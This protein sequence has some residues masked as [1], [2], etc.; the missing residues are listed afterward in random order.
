MALLGRAEKYCL[1][2]AVTPV[3]A[4]FLTSLIASADSDGPE[5]APTMLIAE[6]RRHANPVAALMQP[7]HAQ[8]ATEAFR[9]EFEFVFVSQSRQNPPATADVDTWRG[10]LRFVYRGLKSWNSQD[11][12]SGHRL[13]TILLAGQLASNGSFWRFSPPGIEKNHSLITLLT[14][15]IGDFKAELSTQAVPGQMIWERESFQRFV[16]ADTNKDWPVLI[17]MLPSFGNA[18]QPF[19]LLVAQIQCLLHLDASR[20]PIA[21]AN[22]NSMITAVFV[23]LAL[24]GDR[25]LELALNTV[26]TRVQLACVFF[27]VSDHNVKLLPA[28]KSLLAQVLVK[29][30]ADPKNWDSWMRCFNRFPSRYPE[31]QEPLGEAMAV[32]PP[33]IVRSYV[34][35]HVMETALDESRVAV[36]VCL[37]A[38]RSKGSQS[39]RL[40]LWETAFRRWD[41][42][43]S[44]AGST[45][46][47]MTATAQSVLDFAVVGHIVEAMPATDVAA[48]MERI[49][50]AYKSAT[51]A[52][53][54]SHVDFRT[55]GYR[56]LTRYQ[57]FA[58]A[59]ALGGAGGDF[60]STVKYSVVN[61]I[62]EPYLAALLPS[63]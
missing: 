56:L 60:L 32:S 19:L 33:D 9:R 28:G 15:M 16:E 21:T 25:R 47:N 8:S 55:S 18:L 20:V 6:V 7:V 39:Q 43:T 5:V 53:H 50:T 52:W 35:S 11:D 26:S 44:V 59:V 12:S 34:N 49:A 48:E 2:E 38:F 37:R 40:V 23:T 10:L 36:G 4:S 54:S 30:T 41:T 27:L 1:E 51:L 17:D 14:R 63:G 57:P 29:V 61:S 42:W 24:P 3:Y 22:V 62:D 31:L 13:V 58:Y 45:D 46:G